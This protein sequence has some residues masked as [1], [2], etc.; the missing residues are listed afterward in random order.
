MLVMVMVV[1]M[2]VMT[3]ARSYSGLLIKM[4]LRVP[5]LRACTERIA[6]PRAELETVCR[7]SC[8]PSAVGSRC[9]RTRFTRSMAAHRPRRA[10]KSRLRD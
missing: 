7:S 6:T 2:M 3:F 1:R 10:A 8:V 5:A 4:L 9:A